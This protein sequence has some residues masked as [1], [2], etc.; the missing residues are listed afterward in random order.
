MQDVL[1]SIPKYDKV[2]KEMKK[3]GF[4]ENGRV[5]DQ[6][7]WFEEQKSRAQ[8]RFSAV[9]NCRWMQELGGVCA[10]PDGRVKQF[11]EITASVNALHGKVCAAVKGR[12][13]ETG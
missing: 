12:C 6:V 4:N 1:W 3:A 9:I 7:L 2:L 5:C 8:F 11:R 13:V 10:K